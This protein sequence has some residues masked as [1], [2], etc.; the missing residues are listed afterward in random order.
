M[1]IKPKVREDATDTLFV[2]DGK[3]AVQTFT[4]FSA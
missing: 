4:S 3:I 2:R 1:E